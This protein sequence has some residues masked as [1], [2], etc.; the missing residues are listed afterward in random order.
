MLGG[1]RAQAASVG[2]LMLWI[3]F[4]AITILLPTASGAKAAPFLAVAMLVAF[5][6]IHSARRLGLR[7]TG[8]LF[9]SAAVI[10]NIYENL[11]ISTGFPFTSI[12]T[13]LELGGLPWAPPPAAFSFCVDMVYSFW[14]SVANQQLP[15]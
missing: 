15:M 11:S 12:S 14:Q 1:K 7:Q 10:A 6:L 2:A 5:C 4:T 9:V 13:S 3:V 8:I